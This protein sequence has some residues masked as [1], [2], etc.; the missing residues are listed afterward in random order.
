MAHT[1]LESW[2]QGLYYYR[3]RNFFIPG[4]EAL[5][6]AS[7]DI[8]HFLGRLQRQHIIFRLTMKSTGPFENLEAL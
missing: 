7:Y 1:L 2:S 5:L 8:F 3:L 4:L 6:D